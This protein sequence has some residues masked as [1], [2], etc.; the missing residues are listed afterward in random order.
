M[1]LDNLR[2]T[3]RNVLLIKDSLFLNDL[4]QNFSIEKHYDSGNFGVQK[5][6]VHR[7]W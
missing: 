7:W 3:F 4:E 6:I 2:K 1:I 5:D